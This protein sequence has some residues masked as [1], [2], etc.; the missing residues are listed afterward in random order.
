MSPVFDPTTMGVN[1]GDG[2][3]ITTEIADNISAVSTV[4][5]FINGI[6]IGTDNSFPFTMDWTIPANGPYDIELLATTYF[7]A[8]TGSVHIVVGDQSYPAD[9]DGDGTLD[10]DEPIPYNYIESLL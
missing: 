1:M 5:F 2:Q 7:G 6:V 4:E 10:A 3:I 9:S 8:Y